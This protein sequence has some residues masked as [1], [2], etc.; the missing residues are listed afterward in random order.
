MP[1]HTEWDT[2]ATCQV[3]VR[4]ADE[5]MQIHGTDE[6]APSP[7]LVLGGDGGGCLAVTGTYTE[8]LAL[9]ERI[10]E[11][12]TAERNH[13]GIQTVPVTLVAFDDDCGRAEC[14]VPGHVYAGESVPC[15]HGDHEHIVALAAPTGAATNVSIRPA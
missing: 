6:P 2:A 8:L 9:V 5:A 15:P 4:T 12:I 3:H 13:S 11:A 1:I 14:A 7:V 10:R